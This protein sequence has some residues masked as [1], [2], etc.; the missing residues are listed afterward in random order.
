MATDIDQFNSL[1]ALV[2]HEMERL[3]IPGVT[4][5]VMRDGAVTAN[6]Y[7]VIS[8]NTNYPTRP[9]TLFQIG[10]NTKV[11]TATLAMIAQEQGLLDLDRPVKEYLPDL[12]LADEKALQTI[13]MR[14]LF[15]HTSGMEGD[16]FEDKYGVGE[17]AL[18]RSVDNAYT[19]AQ[20]TDPGEFWSYCNSGFYL[21]GRVLEVILGQSYETATAERVFKP[22]KLDHT[23]WFANEAIV[24]SAAAGHTQ[25]AGQP[26]AQVAAPYP[27]PRFCN[28]AGAII[29][30][31]YDLCAFLKFHLGDG[32]VD[33]ERV[34]SDASVRA[35]Q[36]SQVTINS[37]QEWGIGWSLRN[38]D[39]MRVVQHG[40]GTNGHIT[41]MLCVPAHNVGLVVLTNSSKGSG[42][43]HSVENWFFKHECGVVPRKPELVAL[44]PEMAE[45][46][47]GVY[48]RPLGS[49]TVTT[50]N[51]SLKFTLR[52]K[53]P[54]SGEEVELP[55][56]V[57]KPLSEWEF[58]ATEGD[59]EDSKLEFIP[60]DGGKAR[61]VRL[62][63]RLAPRVA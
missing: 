6:G 38:V 29:S 51:G 32:T 57:A 36:A 1:E 14:H 9:D 15:T 45:K 35:M 33:G 26:R 55:P 8:L 53:N 40:G 16:I 11:F 50:E 58:I 22:L 23:F 19:W 4:V 61:F 10:S 47:T 3:Q 46:V 59:F 52:M 39:G 44:S 43:I 60:G 48:A 54:F 24:H 63:G 7:G 27:I 41:Q 21:A 34:L 42:L 25:E 18:A 2:K 20:E 5:A 62:G 31:V 49:T 12:Q 56:I 13:T 37:E 17:D 30:N 28:P